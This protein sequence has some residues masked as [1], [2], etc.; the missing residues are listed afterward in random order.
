MS[1]T[2]VLAV[3]VASAVTPTVCCNAHA[4][5]QKPIIAHTYCCVDQVSSSSPRFPPSGW[6]QQCSVDPFSQNRLIPPHPNVSNSPSH[7][8]KHK[9]LTVRHSP[10]KS[11]LVVGHWRTE[12]CSPYQY[13]SGCGAHHSASTTATP[14]IRIMSGLKVWLHPRE[15]SGEQDACHVFSPRQYYSFDEIRPRWTR[16]KTAPLIYILGGSVD[17]S[18]QLADIW[19]RKGNAAKQRCRCFSSISCSSIQQPPLSSYRLVRLCGAHAGL[20]HRAL[21]ARCKWRKFCFD[22]SYPHPDIML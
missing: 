3:N 18:L 19:N 20:G 11:G 6:E 1:H 21:L 14:E 17:G 13:L 22:C 9:M 5:K 8:N 16:I 4:P 15:S 10:A 12:L 7:K 2:E